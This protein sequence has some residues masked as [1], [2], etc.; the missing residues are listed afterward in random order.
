MNVYFRVH[1]PNLLNEIFNNPGTVMLTIPFKVFA[2]KLEE[3]A[4]RAAQLNDP[5]LNKLM[6]ELA[7]YEVADP[8]SPEYDPA[9]LE[10]YGVS[11]DDPIWMKMRNS[12]GIGPNGVFGKRDFSSFIPP[13][14]I[15]AAQEIERLTQEK[16]ALQKLVDELKK[17]IEILRQ[18]GNKTCTAMADEVL[19]EMKNPI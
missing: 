14:C 1:T 8:K 19:E 15:E 2:G 5:K 13:I 9:I 18:Y 3:V 11:K 16:E 10:K 7:L 4:R 12:Y 17:E 6:M